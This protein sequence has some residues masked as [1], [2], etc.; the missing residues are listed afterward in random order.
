MEAKIIGEVLAVYFENPS[1]FYKVVRIFVEED[2]DN[3]FVEDE[4]VITGQFASL[5]LDTMYEFYGQLNHHP[6]YGDQFSVS[7]Y[8][9]IEPTSEQGLIDY[10]SSDR[11]K[12][13]GPVLA[14][15]IVGELGMNVIDQ[16]IGDA[17]VLYPI[18]G[19]SKKV[20]DDLHEELRAHRGTERIFMQLNEWGFGPR[21]AE[22][23]YHCYE[24]STIEAIK[25]NPYDL[26][27]KIEGI[28]FN[29][30]DQLAER[31][32]MDASA[33]ERIM[34]GIY[35]AISEWSN[36]QGDTY[37]EVQ[38]ALDHA[39]QLLEQSRH[40]LIQDDQLQAA[41]DRALSLEVIYQIDQGLMIP[42]LYFAEL[43]AARLIDQYLSYEDVDRF[44]EKEIDQVIDDVNTIMGIQYDSRQREA[45]KL[46]IQ[47][48]MSIITGGP[49]TGK[50]TLIRGI[51]EAHLLLHELDR[52]AISKHPEN[53]PILLAAPTGRA[54]KRMQETTG[55]EA[56][57]IHRLIGFNRESLV[58]EFHGNELEGS[59]LVVDEMSMVDTWLMHWLMQSIPPHMQVVFVGDQ[60]QLP[61]VGPGQVFKDLIDS[62]VIPTITLTEIYRQAQNST[63]IQL[64]HQIR[65]G[66]LPEDFLEKKSDRTFIPAP[67]QQIPKVVQKIV[68]FARNKSFDSSTLQVLAPK[69]KGPAGI[70]QLNTI[71]QDLLNPPSSSKR[72]VKHFETIFRTGDK[73]LQLVNN[74]D[75]GVYN[76][77]IGYIQSIVYKGEDGNLTDE[78]RVL[79]D[80]SE[81]SYKPSDLDQL[82]LAYCT[83]IHKAQGSEYDLVILPLVDRYSRLLR[84]DILYTAVT[85]AQKSLVMIGDPESFQIAASNMYTSRKTNLCDLLRTQAGLELKSSN[86]P[87]FEKNTKNQ[88]EIIILDTLA[89]P[90]SDITND[91]KAENSQA[92]SSSKRL[93]LTP[94]NYL[95]IDP[96]I[97]MEGIHLNE[98]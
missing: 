19:L 48:P 65:Q 17:T 91:P 52:E 96:M 76:G 11:F 67:S 6:K 71:L 63:I 33:P 31:L 73:V 40:E 80:E 50:T 13:I 54:A 36:R 4:I 5:H 42:S 37:M 97:G 16:I 18:P 86:K 9:Q 14:E 72:E 87:A 81:L 27:Q 7:R 41:K 22:K 39:R 24:S 79:F 84:Q 28:G 88:D 82:T 55:L 68:E 89:S 59:L 92:R 90:N 32:G 1:N 83:S 35:S 26:V 2:E 34:A 47:S 15:R 94:D 21:L 20:A 49:G 45:I 46:A 51:I 66:S 95:T 12:G 25:E 70:I 69:Y 58:D 29:K 38:L 57:T 75:D 56:S 61:S 98:S 60:D 62:Q 43:G 74:A 53:N 3:L 77:D 93:I 44:E 85:R 23:I 64:A 8:Q 30:A 10:L 78:V